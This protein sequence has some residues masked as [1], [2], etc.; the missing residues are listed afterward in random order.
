M[1]VTIENVQETEKGWLKERPV[2]KLYVTLELTNEEKFILEKKFH[3]Q[4]FVLVEGVDDPNQNRELPH[5]PT[6]RASRLLD[7]PF[8]RFQIR[9]LANRLCVFSH[10]DIDWANYNEDLLREGFRKW[11]EAI[12]QEAGYFVKRPEKKT[13]EL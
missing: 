4:G 12:D 5:K 3:L 7:T 9:G 6:I 10:R 11:K 2:H 1:K 13:L 8:M